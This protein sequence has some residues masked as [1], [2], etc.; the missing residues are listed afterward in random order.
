MHLVRRKKFTQFNAN[1]SI[2]NVIQGNANV[3]VPADS[4]TTQIHTSHKIMSRKKQIT[5]HNT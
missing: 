3:F 2:I 1:I 5:E 4:D